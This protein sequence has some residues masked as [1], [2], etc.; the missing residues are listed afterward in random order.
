M[1]YGLNDQ[2]FKS[3]QVAGDFLFSSTSILVLGPNK[4]PVQWVPVFFPGGG[5]KWTGLDDDCSS[6]SFAEV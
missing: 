1:G 6:P 5:V 3:R 2:D 4:T